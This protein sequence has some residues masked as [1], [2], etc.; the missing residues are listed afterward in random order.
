[1]IFR[2]YSLNLLGV[3][4]L[5][6]GSVLADQA[7]DASLADAKRSVLQQYE[8][9]VAQGAV[10]HNDPENSFYFEIFTSPNDDELKET[11][12]A[13]TEF[14]VQ[15]AAQLAFQ[16]QLDAGE[17]FAA[18]ADLIRLGIVAQFEQRAF[19]NFESRVSFIKRMVATIAGVRAQI[20]VTKFDQAKAS[21]VA[22]AALDSLR[23]ELGLLTLGASLPVRQGLAELLLDL[24][25]NAGRD[26]VGLVDI[27]EKVLMLS[28]S[29]WPNLFCMGSEEVGGLSKI[30]ARHVS[31]FKR[32]LPKAAQSSVSSLMPDDL[33]EDQDPVDNAWLE[34]LSSVIVFLRGGSATSE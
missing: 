13:L 34:K 7:A 1:M 30:V 5:F 4:A 19:N 12:R 6:M 28:L 32:L 27:S 17:H 3:S 8:Q 22:Q 20:D 23:L 21:Q 25:R 16:T 14:S 26:L 15:Q 33:D 11:Q 9:A 31:R 10:G 29:N 2:R 18:V 24:E